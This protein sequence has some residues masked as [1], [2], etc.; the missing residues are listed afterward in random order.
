M[1]SSSS[2]PP[3]PI[4][5]GSSSCS[6]CTL[7]G[8]RPFSSLNSDAGASDRVVILDGVAVAPAADVDEPLYQ[9]ICFW[10]ASG[11]FDP[12]AKPCKTT[13]I[14]KSSHHTDCR[15]TRKRTCSAAARVLNVTIT[16]PLSSVSTAST[17]YQSRTACVPSLPTS[18]TSSFLD[19]LSSFMLARGGPPRAPPR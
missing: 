4:T 10:P 1:P 14:N 6:E 17:S 7:N 18:L 16:S 5:A 8:S 12:L 2:S 11:M 3:Q 19:R 13:R 15:D 9:L